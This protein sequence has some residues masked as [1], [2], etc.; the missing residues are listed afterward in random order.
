MKVSA[1][2]CLSGKVTKIIVSYSQGGKTDTNDNVIF[3][4]FMIN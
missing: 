2:F 3:L 1:G 4:S